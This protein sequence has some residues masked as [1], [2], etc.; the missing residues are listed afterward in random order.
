MYLIECPEKKATRK[1]EGKRAGGDND[2]GG[3][4]GEA[5]Y[6]DYR[7]HRLEMATFLRQP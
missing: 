6:T 3:L 7:V 2:E 1:Y 5:M 4:N